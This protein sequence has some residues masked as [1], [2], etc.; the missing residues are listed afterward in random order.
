MI[1][2]KEIKYLASLQQKKFR[3]LHKQMEQI[4]NL[5]ESP[6]QIMYFAS[7][8]PAIMPSSFISK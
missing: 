4:E 6:F 3:L 2:K 8:I 7:S 1:N 5:S